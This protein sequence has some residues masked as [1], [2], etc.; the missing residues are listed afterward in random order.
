MWWRWSTDYRPAREMKREAKMDKILKEQEKELAQT[1]SSTT[2]TVET[3][4]MGG[5][6]TT[7]ATTSA[8]IPAVKDM[9]VSFGILMYHYIDDKSPTPRSAELHVR[10]EIL[11][12]QIKELLSKGY[13]FVTLD[14]AYD[15]FIK[16]GK[17]P[18]KTLVLT[19]DDGYRSF[20]TDAY[21]I[22]KKYKVPASFYI[23]SND[24]GHAGNVTWDMLKELSRDPLI[25][26][27]AHTMS[28]RNLKK[29][30]DD[31]QRHEL[32]QNKKDLEEK[33]GIKVTTI[34]YPYGEYN[35]STKRIAKELGFK[36]GA[37]VYNGRR[38]STNDYFN[39][40]RVLIQNKDVGD[41]LIRVLYGAFE[42]VK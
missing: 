40:R 25:E 13:T 26:I 3:P 23:I 31:E 5:A 37:A 16:N 28:H 4:S 33:L 2:S 39:W 17:T 38:P 12:Q 41:T 7:T 10:P 19:F 29:M 11:D 20:Y 27:G 18:P 42:I 32:G 36:G 14:Q 1:V 15:M 21:P 9:Q 30:S 24:I 6:A 8:K 35:T 22:L 34:V